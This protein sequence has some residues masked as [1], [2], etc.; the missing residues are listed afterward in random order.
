MGVSRSSDRGRSTC[1]SRSGDLAAP[2]RVRSSPDRRH[3]P[4]HAT[5]R[6]SGDSAPR[7]AAPP[8]EAAHRQSC[9]TTRTHATAGTVSPRQPAHRQGC[10]TRCRATARTSRHSQDAPPRP[11]RRAMA[12][13]A[14]RCVRRARTAPAATSM[15]SSAV[16]GRRASAHPGGA[17]RCPLQRRWDLSQRHQSQSGSQPSPPPAPSSSA[18]AGCGSQHP[19]GSAAGSALGCSCSP[20]EPRSASQA[21][22]A[23]GQIT[24][25]WG[26]WPPRRR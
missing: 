6:R 14:W 15:P 21:P 20:M 19:V 1:W 22:L 17:Y 3:E 23:S 8:R 13:A 11:G 18:G 4:D 5:H 16:A 9:A 24:Q 2:M 10:G 12:R 7:R 26:R 25:S